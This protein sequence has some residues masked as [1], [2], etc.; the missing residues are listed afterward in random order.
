MG[1]HRYDYIK[2]CVQ[3]Q[4][5]WHANARNIR[6]VLTAQLRSYWLAKFTKIAIE[7]TFIDLLN[8]RPLDQITVTDIVNRCGVNRNTF[9]YY[10]EDVYA[11]ID[12]IFR[13]QTN[14]LLDNYPVESVNSL[15]SGF[16][17]ATKFMR[18]N[19]TAIFHLYNSL[20][21]GRLEEYVYDIAEKTVDRFI[22]A[23]AEGMNV[24]EHDLNVLTRLY[25]SAFEGVALRWMSE[26]MSVDP[27]EYINDIDRLIHGVTKSIL[28]NASKDA[29]DTS[30]S[31][32]SRPQNSKKN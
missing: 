4:A 10:F 22:H 7:K 15:K 20:N 24:S 26:G 14:E 28:K 1:L 5:L 16:E 30:S 27:I 21:R 12:E 18:E 31:D 17:V 32:S 19:K 25:T 23:Q 3:T 13:E 2:N 8:E 9:Y 6:R 11:L 29:A